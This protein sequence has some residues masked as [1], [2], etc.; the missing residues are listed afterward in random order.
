MSPLEEDYQ[1]SHPKEMKPE[2]LKGQILRILIY[3]L[4]R[5]ERNKNYIDILDRMKKSEEE[6]YSQE[7]LDILSKVQR[8]MANNEIINIDISRLKT[9][10]VLVEDLYCPDG[11]LILKSGYELSE[12]MILLIKNFERLE[13]TKIKVICY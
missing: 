6:I 5:F 1:N 11:R 13:A 2:V 7:I 3:Y 4:T 12:E 10:M 9:D 8:D